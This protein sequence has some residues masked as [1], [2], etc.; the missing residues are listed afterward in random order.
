MEVIPTIE[1]ETSLQNPISPGLQ[2]G[3]C[4]AVTKYDAVLKEAVK[5]PLKFNPLYGNL[6]ACIEDCLNW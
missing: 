1:R 5:N 6:P 4:F 2:L 3:I